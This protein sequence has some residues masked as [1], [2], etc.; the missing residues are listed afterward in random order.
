MPPTEVG[1]GSVIVRIDDTCGN[2]VQISQ[3]PRW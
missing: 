2:L 3:V 1:G